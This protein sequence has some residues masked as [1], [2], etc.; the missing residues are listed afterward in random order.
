MNKCPVKICTPCALP[1][2]KLRPLVQAGLFLSED[3]MGKDPAVLFYT[4][5]FLTGTIL[6]SM[7]ERGQYIT[8]LCMQHQA[9]HLSMQEIESVTLSDRV[10]SKFTLCH[11]GKYHNQRMHEEK[12][13]RNAFCESRRKSI[14]KRY[15]KQ[16]NSTYVERTNNVRNTYE[17]TYELRMENG[18][19][20]RNISSSEIKSIDQKTVSEYWKQFCAAYPKNGSCIAPEAEKLFSQLVFNGDSP[21]VIIKRA[22]E[23]QK[24]TVSAFGPSPYAKYVKQAQNWLRERAFCID[25]SEKTIENQKDNENKPELKIYDNK[26][27]IEKTEKILKKY[28]ECDDPADYAEVSAIINNLA[29]KKSI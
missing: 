11:D 13:K 3:F 9:G 29:K 12:E 15:D 25:W 6:M 22:S 21:E 10:K 8:L 23:Y 18:N 5:D 17:H 28:Q 4:S 26:K 27:E 7:E 16:E 19:E 24:Y 1:V 2:P 20:N 14:K